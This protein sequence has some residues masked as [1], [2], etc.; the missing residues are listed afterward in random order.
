MVG[1][2]R[3]LLLAV[4]VHMSVDHNKANYGW[5]G[6]FLYNVF[7]EPHE[8]LKCLDCTIFYLASALV[9]LY[10]HDIILVDSKI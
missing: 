8:C 6:L 9:N 1:G 3:A 10:S 5:L 7:T 4:A 2:F